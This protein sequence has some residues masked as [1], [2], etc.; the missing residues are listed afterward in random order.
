MNSVNVEFFGRIGVLSDPF[1]ADFWRRGMVDVGVN[2]Q[3]ERRVPHQC[4]TL[5]RGGAFWV[6]IRRRNTSTLW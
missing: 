2:L 4:G 5:R 1:V 3:A 6:L